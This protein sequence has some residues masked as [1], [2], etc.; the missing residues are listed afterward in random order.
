MIYNRLT[1][2]I[3]CGL[4]GIY[5][6]DYERSQCVVSTVLYTDFVPLCKKIGKT[7]NTGITPG[8]DTFY[9]TAVKGPPPGHPTQLQS[10]MTVSHHWRVHLWQ[11]PRCQHSPLFFIRGMV[12]GNRKKPNHGSFFSSAKVQGITLYSQRRCRAARDQSPTSRYSA[13]GKMGL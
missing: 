5:L 8:N 7:G 4:I 10:V 3:L 2:F 9:N 11:S 13:V 6:S 12:Q 1:K